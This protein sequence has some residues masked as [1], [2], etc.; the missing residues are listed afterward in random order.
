MSDL[1]NADGSPIAPEAQTEV[2]SPDAETYSRNGNVQ[3]QN[4]MSISR[5]P[6]VSFGSAPAR[7]SPGEMNGVAPTPASVTSDALLGVAGIPV[8]V[9]PVDRRTIQGSTP[10]DS[11]K[12]G[13]DAQLPA[14]PSPRSGMT[15]AP[16]SGK[17]S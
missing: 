16:L 9:K 13:A 12:R 3:S 5:G 7:V 17:Q 4:T 6:E 1:K 14:N 11:R 8:T 10:G 15:Q 2:L